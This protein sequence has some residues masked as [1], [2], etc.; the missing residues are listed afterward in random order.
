MLGV[1]TRL[2]MEKI[3]IPRY[4]VISVCFL[5][6]VAMTGLQIGCIV[7]IQRMKAS[8]TSGNLVLLMFVDIFSLMTLIFTLCF[9]GGEIYLFRRNLHWQINRK[10]FQRGHRI[11]EA[12]DA[13]LN[14]QKLE[15]AYLR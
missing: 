10:S 13:S 6:M 15:R 7:E 4:R 5:V 9:H 2:S 12:Q 8:F 14:L 3:T 1:I 11:G